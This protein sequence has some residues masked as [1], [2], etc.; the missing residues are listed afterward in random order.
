M[1]CR[2]FPN[3]RRC[4]RAGP[5]GPSPLAPW[6][7]G[8]RIKSA[9]SAGVLDAFKARGPDD[10]GGANKKAGRGPGLSVNICEGLFLEA[11]VLLRVLLAGGEIAVFLDFQGVHGHILTGGLAGSLVLGAGDVDGDGHFHFRVQRQ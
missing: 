8:P 3:H 7:S 6:E 5:V 11:V 2:L 4:P 1:L 10:I 9:G